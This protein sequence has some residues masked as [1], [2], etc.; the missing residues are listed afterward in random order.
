MTTVIKRTYS[1]RSKPTPALS[2]PSTNKRKAR[3]DENDGS[4]FTQKKKQRCASIPSKP[5]TLATSRPLKPSQQKT[6]TQLHFV[7][8]SS[9]LRACTLCGLSYTRGT[10]DDEALHRSHCGRVQRGMEWGRE[11][12]KESFKAGVVEV[13]ANVRIKN[14]IC[15]RIICFPTNVGGKIGSKLANLLE[16]INL[17]LTSPPLA[18]S[19]LDN[20][21]AYLFLIPSQTNSYREKI[22]GCVVAQRISTAMTIASPEETAF[23]RTHVGSND[24]SPEISPKSLVTKPM[25][26]LVAVDVA[27]GLFCHPTALPTPLGVPRLFVSSSHRRQGIATRLLTAAAETFIHGCPLDP[28]K[29]EVAFTQPTE[30]GNAVMKS[31]GKGFVRIYQE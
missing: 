8:D 2:S 13:S 11:E 25:T 9:V 31:W 10:P 4:L 1:A 7:L 12:E 5:K 3:D 17:A 22:V 30:G 20:S 6:L 19:V 21:K 26:S 18:E 27:S 23:A 24:N 28:L 29:G 16:T 15:G 14:G